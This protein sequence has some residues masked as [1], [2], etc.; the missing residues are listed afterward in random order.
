MGYNGNFKQ[1]LLICL[2]M[3]NFERNIMLQRSNL[4]NEPPVFSFLHME[5]TVISMFVCLFV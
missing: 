5:N 3:A 1:S 2:K 4:N